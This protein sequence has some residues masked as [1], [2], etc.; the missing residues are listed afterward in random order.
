MNNRFKKWILQ[1][2][3]TDK[4]RSIAAKCHYDNSYP[5]LLS[6]QNRMYE[7]LS[8]SSPGYE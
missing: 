7:L 2:K 4:V 1:E 3:D 8:L 6:K 5:I